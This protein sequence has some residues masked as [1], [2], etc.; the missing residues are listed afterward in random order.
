MNVAE[1]E[2][3]EALVYEIILAG[4]PAKSWK[5]PQGQQEVVNFYTHHSTVPSNLGPQ[6]K[7]YFRSYDVQP[8]SKD[9]RL[10]NIHQATGYH[11]SLINYHAIEAG[12]YVSGFPIEY[13]E[14]DVRGILDFGQ[15]NGLQMNAGMGPRIIF[16]EKSSFEVLGD[17]NAQSDEIY[18]PNAYEPLEL[19]T[20][21]DRFLPLI[22]TGHQLF[23][24]GG[25]GNHFSP[26][27]I[28]YAYNTKLY[29]SQIRDNA[30]F[31]YRVLYFLNPV[32]NIPNAQS[33]SRMVVAFGISHTTGKKLRGFGSM[34]VFSASDVNFEAST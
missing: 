9:D 23:F 6:E 18:T 4:N 5:L 19:A 2:V 10:G 20:F 32:I 29:F 12:D 21:P 11:A 14:G 16:S 17:P 13:K 8:S 24:F 28:Q 31:R 33:D 27:K 7:L 15:L 34:G 30:I 1:M 26:F 22:K 3:A 25:I